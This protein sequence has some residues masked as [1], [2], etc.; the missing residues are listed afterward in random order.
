MA[1]CAARAGDGG[2]GE[3]TRREHSPDQTIIEFLNVLR[4]KKR[5]Y[6]AKFDAVLVE[7]GTKSYM[8]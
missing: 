8:L 2:V 7:D 4:I 1:S 6:W 5:W 3:L